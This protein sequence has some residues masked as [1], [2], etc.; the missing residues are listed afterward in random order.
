MSVYRK[1]DRLFLSVRK[2]VCFSFFRSSARWREAGLQ[3]LRTSTSVAL[4]AEA[5]SAELRV[6]ETL[7]R[8]LPGTGAASQLAVWI[9]DST[10]GV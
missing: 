9:S 1:E 3:S 6:M 8:A 5:S 4:R 7:A 2:C 10:F